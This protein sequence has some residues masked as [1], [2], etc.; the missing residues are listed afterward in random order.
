MTSDI[1]GTVTGIQGNP[2]VA[3]TLGAAQD[4]YVLTWD[5]TDGYIVARPTE[6]TYTGLRQVYFTSSGTWT[7]PTG[8]T[9]V[10]VIASGGGGGGGGGS[11]TLSG[12]GGGG[13]IEQCSYISVSSGTNYTVTIGNGG[14]G[15]SGGFANGS[16][17]SNGNSTILQNG[18]TTIF[19]AIGAGGGVAGGNGSNYGIGGSNWG[20][21]VSPISNNGIIAAGGNTGNSINYGETGHPNYKNIYSGGAGG[22]PVNN[23]GG[24]ATAGGG[25]GA[26][27]QGNGGNG[28]NGGN[29]TTGGS[30]SNASSN[31]G[32]GGGGGGG[33]S[34]GGSGYDGGAGGNGGS[35]YLYII[36]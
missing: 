32:A 33:G 11:L 35:G 26:G 21:S 27:P 18:G 15:A 31:T 9:N 3:E 5:N 8:I 10:L 2:V 30:G 28:G 17:G 13:A 16:N 1:N 29:A 34:N 22:S 23:G 24:M 4:G 25:G 20:T 7:C 19:S 12:G 14:L 36:Y 6:Q